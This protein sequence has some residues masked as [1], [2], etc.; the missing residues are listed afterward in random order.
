MEMC[1]NQ[2][3]NNMEYQITNIKLHLTHLSKKFEKEYDETLILHKGS[4]LKSLQKIMYREQCLKLKDK[5]KFIDEILK[6]IKKSEYDVPT[7]QFIERLK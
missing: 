2:I 1:L 5:L 4:R 6:K 3:N 7:V